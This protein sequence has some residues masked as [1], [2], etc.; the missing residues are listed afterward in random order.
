MQTICG[1]LGTAAVAMVCMLL[2]CQ[3]PQ[4]F[5]EHKHGKKP[6]E[7][8][9]T[10]HKR[11]GYKAW[12]DREDRALEA[13]KCAEEH[14]REAR[15]CREEQEREAR[16]HAEE[17]RRESSKHHDGHGHEGSAHPETLPPAQGPKI[18]VETG[19]GSIG[20]QL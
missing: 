6:D 12:K 11:H 3:V 14:E 17:Q 10:Y 15:K 20:V 19:Y 13:W 16:K 8:A 4:S 1:R 5:G 9:S 18:D 7:K 2:T